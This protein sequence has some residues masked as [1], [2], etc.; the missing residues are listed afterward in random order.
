MPNVTCSGTVNNYPPLAQDNLQLV[1]KVPNG[2]KYYSTGVEPPVIV[3]H[4]TG[5]YY[6]AGYAYG[7]LLSKE[8]QTI[9]P[10]VRRREDWA[11][12]ARPGGATMVC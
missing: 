3:V 11:G 5:D 7:Q 9:L 6:E 1:S 2:A 12:F 8:I 10:L 4:V